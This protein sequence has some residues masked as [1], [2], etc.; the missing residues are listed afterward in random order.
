[1]AQRGRF[2][3]L[4]RP[5]HEHAFLIL[6]R[7]ARQSEVP[8]GS[9]IEKVEKAPTLSKEWERSPQLRAGDGDCSRTVRI[10]DRI[11]ASGSRPVTESEAGR[12]VRIRRSDHGRFRRG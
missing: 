1:V 2:V 7:E 4:Y 3:V 12:G 6:A 9:Q 11:E 5:A 10:L 8:F